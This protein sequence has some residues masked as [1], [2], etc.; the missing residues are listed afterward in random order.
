MLEKLRD[1]RQTG[2]CMLI[3]GKQ[4]L[5]WS[6]LCNTRISYPLTTFCHE[7]ENISVLLRDLILERQTFA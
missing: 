7:L 4:Q 1:F 2:P 3:V 5:F 6:V